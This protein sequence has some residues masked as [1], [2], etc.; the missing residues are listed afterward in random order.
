MN[1]VREDSHSPMP[2]LMSDAP[3]RDPL[4]LLTVADVAQIL[5][6]K[7]KTVY[8]WVGQ[9]KIRYVKVHGALRFLRRDLEA[10]MMPVEVIMSP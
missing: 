5:R 6:V 1:P 9:R 7:P 4:Q 10:L 8:A 2:L 3:H